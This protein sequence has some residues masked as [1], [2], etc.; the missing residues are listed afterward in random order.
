MRGTIFEQF[1]FYGIQSL[2]NSLIGTHES[3]LAGYYHGESPHRFEIF[4][5]LA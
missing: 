4:L 2:F 5:F 3:N 1:A